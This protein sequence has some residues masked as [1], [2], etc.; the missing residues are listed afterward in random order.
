MGLAVATVS[1]IFHDVTSSY[2]MNLNSSANTV[3]E[4]S[5]KKI[6]ISTKKYPN[7][8]A[9]V[10]DENYKD[11]NKF[12]W[13][14]HKRKDYYQ[15]LRN[16]KKPYPRGAIF[17]SREV[18]SC[19]SKDLLV[20]HKDH[21]GLNNCKNNLRVCTFEENCRNRL[22]S[23]GRKYKGVF[24]K[25]KKWRAVLRYKYKDVHMGYFHNEID[26]AKAY[27]IAAIKYFGPFAYLNKV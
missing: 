19:Q 11:L 23:S 27:N 9:L 13:H 15:V 24:K 17:M 1:P 7:T 25:N 8:Y 18:M 21:N 26:A 16:A 3:K 20:D 2:T 14:V 22:P 5:M 4:Q 10:D 12:K 6:N